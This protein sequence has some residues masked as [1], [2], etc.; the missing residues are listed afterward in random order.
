M[1]TDGVSKPKALLM[2]YAV[3]RFGPRWSLKEIKTCPDNT[4]CAKPG[5]LEISLIKPQPR[6]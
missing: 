3:V 5:D 1:I 2:Y 4:L 6:T